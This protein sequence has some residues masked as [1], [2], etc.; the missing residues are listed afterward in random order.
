M[1]SDNLQ[2]A[3][4]LAISHIQKGMVLG[5]GSG[6]TVNLFIDE[7]AKAKL[8]FDIDCIVPAS[9]A[10]KAKLLSHNFNVVDLNSVDV[11]LYIDSCDEFNSLKELIKGGG[12]ALTREK[13]IAS[14]AKQFICIAGN[15]KFVDVFGKFPIAV[16]VISMARGLVARKLL[17]MG[18]NPSLRHEYITD[19]GNIIIDVHGLD[20]SN[21]ELLEK[22]INNIPGV[23]E[24]GIFSS[25]KPSK[26]IIIDEN[27]NRLL[28]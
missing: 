17:S 27:E 8:N 19:N 12:G 23:V 24:T 6:S 3:F 1:N 4:S 11:D 18:G 25:I 21:V 26:I 28:E 13:I 10:T 14:S 5:L 20:L 7:L 2:K 9:E 22:E 15:S 16:E